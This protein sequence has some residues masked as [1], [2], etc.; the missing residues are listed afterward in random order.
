MIDPTDSELCAVPGAVTFRDPDALDLSLPVTRFVP[1][2]P[3]DLDAYD[4]IYER[5][6]Q[7]GGPRWVW[8]DE[9]RF[10]FPA[11]GTKPWPAT[12]HI[13]GRKR[14]LGHAV[15][16]TRCSN[17]NLEILGLA[18][19][20]ITFPLGHGEDRSVLA[21][22][23]GVDLATL[24]ACYAELEPFGFLWFRRGPG[25]GELTICPPL[26]RELVHR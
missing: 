13:T 20:V 16:N 22:S 19:H 9:G 26:P 11:N 7:A 1:M 10:P 8:C 5:M 17:I 2:H 4:R 3:N 12:Y 15:A 14:E 25:G 6:Y 18:A 24:D 23:I 21:K